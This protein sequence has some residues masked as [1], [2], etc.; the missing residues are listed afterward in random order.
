MSNEQFSFGPYAEEYA[1]LGLPVIMVKRKGKE[2][3]QLGWPSIATTDP[4]TAHALW[5]GKNRLFNIGV[6][7][8]ERAGIIDIET[9]NHGGPNGEESLKGYMEQAGECLPVTWAFQSGSGGI[10]RLFKCNR[11]IAKAEAILPAVDVRANGS[12]AVMPPSVHPN[13][14]LYKWLE[15]QNPTALPDGPADLPP[16]IL[17]LLTEKTDKATNTAFE[18]PEKIPQG[19]RDS[20]LFKMAS[21]LRAQEY[22]EDEI[23][24]MLQVV[25][26][27]RCDP[28]LTDKQLEKICKSVGKYEPGVSR[29][30]RSKRLKSP[31]L[32]VHS[33][34]DLQEKDLPPIRWIVVDMIPQ[35]LTLLA[36]P[37]K[38]GKSW[39][40]LDLCLSVA[41]GD[42]FM[43]HSTEKSGCLYLALEDSENRLQNRINRLTY[44][45]P[46]PMDFEYSV[47][48]ATLDTGLIEQLEAYLKKRP[49]TSLIVVDTL[50]KV[51]GRAAKNESA[52]ADDYQQ[53]TLLKRFADDHG[54][55]ILLVHHLKKGKGEGDVFERISGTNGIFG[56]ADTAIVMQKERRT[57]KETTLHITGRDVVA[58]DTV[59]EFNKDS[60]RWEC[61]GSVDE[62]EERRLTLEY[63]NDPVVCTVK[64]LLEDAPIWIGTASDLFAACIEITGT[65]P[66]KTPDSLGRRIRATA[67]ML[68]TR[69]QIFYFPP[70][71]NGG[72]GGRKHTFRKNEK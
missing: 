60:C 19:E 62:V 1:A 20:T 50:Q 70:G 61:K 38:Y 9:D 51:K 71:K 16:C 48:A 37:P 52:Y 45:A 11:P 27:R 44:N 66:D 22:A 47:T 49:N 56:S 36:S 10:H 4:A 53:M 58:D 28:P 43:N 34:R 2:A 5:D 6:V 41:A 54:I 29:S 33:A 39:W 63:E 31:E 55:C 8:G 67:K 24:S 64:K 65:P 69:D 35:G 72:A 13:G 3:A 23:F 15:G 42:R 7:M 40:V 18:L 32:N 57:D 14:E 21:S 26:N 25:N 46:A 59:I 12:Y 30:E 68:F 17:A